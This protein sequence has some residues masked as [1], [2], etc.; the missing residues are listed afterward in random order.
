MMWSVIWDNVIRS[1]VANQLANAIDVH[2][3][4]SIQDCRYTVRRIRRTGSQTTPSS[5][6]RTPTTAREM[7]WVG[8]DLKI[9]CE[10]PQPSCAA[11]RSIQRLFQVEGRSKR[12]LWPS[13]LE[14]VRS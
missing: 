13:S 14:A 11:W 6:S 9:E 1:C 8:L 10:A 2:S 12:L 4:R 7:S 5:E 3:R